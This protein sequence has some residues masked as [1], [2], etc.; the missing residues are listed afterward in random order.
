MIESYVTFHKSTSHNMFS[1]AQQDNTCESDHLL[2]IIKINAHF[3]FSLPTT[4][5]LPALHGA[6][7][8]PKSLL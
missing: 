7:L 5:R 6:N 3:C 2:F 8:P 1:K 4:I